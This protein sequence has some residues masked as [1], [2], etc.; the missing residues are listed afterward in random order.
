MR[1][2]FTTVI[3]LALITLAMPVLADDPDVEIHVSPIDVQS[4]PTQIM[5]KTPLQQAIAEIQQPRSRWI[6]HSVPTT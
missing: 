3:L 1:T 2:A 4:D 6:K 5:V